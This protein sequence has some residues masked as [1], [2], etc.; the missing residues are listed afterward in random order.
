MD[1]QLRNWMC[2]TRGRAAAVTRLTVRAS[3]IASVG[4]VTGSDDFALAATLVRDAGELAAR[5]L[6]EGLTTEHKTS[7][8]DVVS[9]ADHAAEELIADRLHSERPDDGVVG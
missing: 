7:I 5:M 4:P 3:R 6:G 2:P 8:S 9:A 1:R